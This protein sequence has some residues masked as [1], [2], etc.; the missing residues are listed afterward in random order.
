[1]IKILMKGWYSSY[2]SH[3]L[4]SLKDNEYFIFDVL[5]FHFEIRALK[6][7]MDP[8]IIRMPYTC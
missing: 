2:R 5:L 4:L 1:M 7:M 6:R 3:A 8:I